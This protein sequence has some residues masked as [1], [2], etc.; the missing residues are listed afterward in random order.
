LTPQYAAAIRAAGPQFSKL[1]EEA[2]IEL[3]VKGVTPEYVRALAA[4]GYGHESVEQIGDAATLGVSAA[5][6]RDYARIAPRRSLEEVTELSILGVTPDFVAAAQRGGAA[7]SKEQLIE[8]RLGVP[9]R[10]RSRTP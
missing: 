7:L 8:L 5:A 3:R 2:L 10:K 9:R 1:D 6:L 4:A